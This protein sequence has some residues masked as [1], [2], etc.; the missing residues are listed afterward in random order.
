MP[1]PPNARVTP[2]PLPPAIV[3]L[4]ISDVIVF[5]LFIPRPPYPSAAKELAA[6]P[7]IMPLLVS[8]VI[9]P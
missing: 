6:P 5:A 7:L 4:L 9:V 8:V 2:V 3:P 1:V